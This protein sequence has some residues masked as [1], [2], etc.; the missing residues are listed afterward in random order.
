MLTWTCTDSGKSGSYSNYYLHRNNFSYCIPEL[1]EEKQQLQALDDKLR[2]WSEWRRTNASCVQHTGHDI[3]QVQELYAICEQPFINYCSHK[4]YR[5]TNSATT[6]YFSP[7]NMLVV[8]LWHLKHYHSECY[9]ASESN[10]SQPAVNY[11]LSTVADILH[12]CVYPELV[13]IPANVSISRTP[14][15]LQQYHKLIVDS[16]FI[17]IPE[18][19]DSEQRKAYYHAKRSTNYALKVQIACDFHHRIV[20][21]SECFRGSV[22]DITILRESELL[23][24]P[25]GRELTDEDKNFNHG[26]NSARAAIENINQRLKAY[27]ILSGVYRGTIDDFHKATKIVQV[28]RALCNLNLIKHPIHRYTK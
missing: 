15:G 8:T 28:V 2:P 26:I 10:L 4:N 18:P 11:L 14:H 17:A 3:E 5:L 9:I 7:M 20:H 27:A 22:H 19:Y 21:V 16:T 6:S 12:S 24:H 1:E 23:E 13:S 25:H